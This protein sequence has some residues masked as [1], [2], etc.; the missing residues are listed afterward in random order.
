[1]EDMLK[2]IV[3][4]DEKESTFHKVEILIQHINEDQS[5]G[6]QYGLCGDNEV[7]VLMYLLKEAIVRGD[8][9]LPD[10]GKYF[11]KGVDRLIFL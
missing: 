2:A 9:Y 11:Q 5:L 3:E 4:A 7:D 10:S 6:K 8:K 1:M